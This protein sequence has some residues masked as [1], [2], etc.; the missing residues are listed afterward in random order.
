M[1]NRSSAKT[2]EF[3]ASNEREKAAFCSSV[4]CA[5]RWQETKQGKECPM[6]C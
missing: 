3:P 6:D 4:P 1:T 2:K 5:C